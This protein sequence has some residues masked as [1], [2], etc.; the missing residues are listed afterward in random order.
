LVSSEGRL[1]PEVKEK[2]E[3][4]LCCLRSRIKV[5]DVAAISKGK[6]DTTHGPVPFE[7]FCGEFPDAIP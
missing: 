5:I 1:E 3:G 6:A 7:T 4:V 2:R